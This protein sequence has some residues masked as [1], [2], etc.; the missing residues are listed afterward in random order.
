MDMKSLEF[1]KKINELQV[2]LENVQNEKMRFMRLN[3]TQ[4]LAELLHEKLCSWNHTDGCSWHYE[5]WDDIGNARKR[6][7][8]KAE[9]IL[10]VSDYKTAEKIIRLI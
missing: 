2:E 9:N 7:L 8:E 10:K 3:R 5:S 6:Y 1:D 4:R